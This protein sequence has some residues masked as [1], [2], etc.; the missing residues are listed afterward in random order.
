MAGNHH[1]DTFDNIP[2][3]KRE[4]ILQAAAKIL[5]R[6]GTSRARMDDIARAAGISH[7]SLFSYFP[8]KDELVRGVIE[9]GETMQRSR[10]DASGDHSF[11]A[12]VESIMSNAWE[13]ASVEDD[14]ISLWVSLSLKENSGFAP[15]V[16]PLERE[17]A[18]RW[19]EIVEQG[20][21]EGAIAESLDRRVVA[22]LLDAI[23]A[24]LMKSRAS[25]LERDKLGFL[26][27][28]AEA[29]PELIVRTLIDLLRPRE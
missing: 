16:L 22:F 19:K 5:G 3:E 14:L 2:E 27:D 26:F 24:Q 21:S 4:R 7:G 13:T 8:T 15:A 18:E 23:A 17:A 11:G 28:D 20:V 1:T 10:F 12:A 6:D 9:R 29:A 25:D